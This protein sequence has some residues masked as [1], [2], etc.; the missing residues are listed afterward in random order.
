MLLLSLALA[1]EI[2]VTAARPVV[3]AIDG[4]PA[5]VAGTLVDTQDLTP[6]EHRVQVRNFVG[7]LLAEGR[8]TVGDR[9]R[10]RLEYDREERTL[11]ELD[12]APL[13]CEDAEHGVCATEVDRSLVIT[14]LSDISGLARVHGQALRFNTD[15]QGFLATGLD[16]PAVEVHLRDNDQLR[17]HGAVELAGGHNT[18]CQLVYRT[19]AWLLDCNADG[20]AHPVPVTDLAPVDPMITAT[21]AAPRP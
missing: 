9:E 15:V 17:F 10:L 11:A 2:Q 13:E 4:R 19:T 16:V 1:S 8:F 14:G 3:V 7:S 18:T 12:R 20:A 6:G 21:T 5:G